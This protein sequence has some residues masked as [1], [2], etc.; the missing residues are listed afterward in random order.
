MERHFLN[1]KTGV[2]DAFTDLLDA[3]NSYD[4]NSVYFNELNSRF[5]SFL[6]VHFVSLST[7]NSD[8]FRKFI[9]RNKDCRKHPFMIA[10]IKTLTTG[11]LLKN[12]VLLLNNNLLKY[13]SHPLIPLFTISVD[14]KADTLKA[15][16]LIKLYKSLTTG[17]INAKKTAQLEKLGAE[18]I[19]RAYLY[20]AET[21]VKAKDIN[22]V[23]YYLKKSHDNRIVSSHIVGERLFSF[24]SKLKNDPTFAVT[25]YEYSIIYGNTDALLFLINYYE[26][27]VRNEAKLFYYL[28]LGAHLNVREAIIKLIAYY[29]KGTHVPVDD[30]IISLLNT[31]LETF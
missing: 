5:V 13:E 18:G 1:D 10:A 2:G 31:K 4:G 28:T 22:K 17:T 11:R 25:L 6:Y 24:A 7:A 8:T 20:L 16:R 9:M 21:Y 19:Y 26:T 23:I 12:E 3:L 29:K 30:E 27:T 15:I 14:D